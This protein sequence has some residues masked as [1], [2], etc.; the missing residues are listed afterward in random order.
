MKVIFV[1]NNKKIEAK[2]EEGFSLLEIAHSND[3][4]LHGNCGGAMACG[5]CH[6]ILSDEWI[7]KLPAQDDENDVLDVIFGVTKNSR[8]GCQIFFDSSMDGMEVV[9]PN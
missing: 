7:G 2:A 4:E 5:S 9:I 3:I 8:L 1:V 6:V